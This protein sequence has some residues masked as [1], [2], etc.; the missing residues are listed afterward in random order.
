MYIRKFSNI[1]KC[2]PSP[3]DIENGELNSIVRDEDF[4]SSSFFSHLYISCFTFFSNVFLSL[5]P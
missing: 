5:V 1:C 4:F 3:F 2:Y